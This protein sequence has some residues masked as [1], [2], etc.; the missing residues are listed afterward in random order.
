MLKK[1]MISFLYTV[2]IIYGLLVGALYYFQRNLLYMP[3]KNIGAPEQ[4]G[5]EGFTDLRTTT[6]DGVAIQLWYR[7]AAGNFPTIVY[8]HGN[9]AHIG[10]RA[11]KLYA[12]AAQGFGVLAVSYR[13]YGASEGAPTETGLYQDARAAIEFLTKTHNVPLAQI[14]FYGESLGTGVAMQ[15]ATEYHIGGVVLEAPY[16]SVAARAAE[17]YFYVPVA[18]LIKDRFDSLGKA[19]SLKAP[20]LLLHGELDQT[21][22]VRQGRMLFSAVA[23]PKKAIYFPHVNHNDF[24]SGVISAHVLDFA[25]EH[26]L[27][28]P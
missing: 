7:K 25:K 22:P 12:L 10:N 5:L 9:A 2:A 24:D 8:F 16:T 6:A 4:Y 27:I 14:M 28:A 18:L 15:M 26:R 3:D 17:I 13:G 11:G 23:S 1:R 21:I 20:L 19:P